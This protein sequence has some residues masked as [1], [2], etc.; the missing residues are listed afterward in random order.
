MAA[1]K[2]NKYITL[3]T[4]SHA[5]PRFRKEFLN[6]HSKFI[7]ASWCLKE[8]IDRELVLN[9]VKYVIF[10]LW[11]V[12]G[13]RYNILL[14]PVEGGPYF[15]ADSK[16]VANALGYTRMR[17]AV[18]GVEHKFDLI[19]KKYIVTP[20]VTALIEDEESEEEYNEDEDEDGFVDPLV[21]ALE[22]DITDDGDTSNY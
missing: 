19:G 1:G 7:H 4:N 13:G 21:K 14:K 12:V 16:M 8:D 17:N 22:D 6:Q 3:D 10:G 18:T 9:D 20:A 15:I 11:D 5:L 2:I